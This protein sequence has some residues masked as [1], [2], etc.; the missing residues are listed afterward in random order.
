MGNDK[1]HLVFDPHVHTRRSHDGSDSPETMAR[2]AKYFGLDAIAFSDHNVNPLSKEKL[3]EIS[4]KFDI[5]IIESYEQGLLKMFPDD[6]AVNIDKHCIGLGSESILFDRDILKVIDHIHKEGGIAIAPHPF[7]RDGYW[8]YYELGFDAYEA[9]NGTTKP[10][11]LDANHLPKV[12]GSDAH[13][14]PDLGYT[15]TR[16]YNCDN[17][18]DDILESIRRGDCAPGGINIPSMHLISRVFELVK[19]YATNPLELL[20]WAKSTAME[21]SSIDSRM[22]KLTPRKA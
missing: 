12:G 19:R 11:K 20:E 6:M 1:E 18:R 16:V 17:N 5:T 21:N 2:W 13:R 10:H 22:P 9:L 3:K 4:R 14:Y 8:N 7:C 15:Y